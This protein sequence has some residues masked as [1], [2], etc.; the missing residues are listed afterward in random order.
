MY[1]RDN[2]RQ[3]FQAF[4]FL[5][6]GLYMLI[7]VV[8]RGGGG[9]RAYAF[10]SIVL[11]LLGLVLGV[12]IFT[13][14]F[15]LLRQKRLMENIPRSK[16][17]SAAMGL[18]EVKG[19]AAPYVWLKS[20]LT[21]TD[22]VYYKFLVEKY[23]QGGKNSHWKVVNEGCSTNFFYVEDETGKILVD[24]VEA[25]LHLSSDY[26]YTGT[27]IISSGR[28]RTYSPP[29]IFGGQ[30]MR[31]TEWYI[32]PSDTVYAIG[33][34][35]KW[36]SA[37]EDHKFKVAEKLKAIKEDKERLKKFDLDGDG[38]IDCDEWEMAR[39]QAEQDLLKEQLEKPQQVEDDVVITRDPSNNI[40]IISDQDERQVI[41]NKKICATLS[42]AS[43][44][45]LILWMAY[46]LLKKFVQ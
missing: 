35:K 38:Q 3:A 44:S 17:R 25:E 2:R 29:S 11:P 27:D 41:K 5:G 18:S 10:F 6:F 31:Y 19:K 34:V 37:F 1:F 33:T 9:F 8:M 42:F 40:M 13:L 43:G 20:P 23:V 28:A 39:Q 26:K 36:K 12:L 7:L 45:G 15:E 32:V 22:C 46:L 16:A 21:T 24:P 14:G 4:A 30:K